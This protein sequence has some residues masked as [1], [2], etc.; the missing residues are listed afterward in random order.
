MG[1]VSS[2]SRADELTLT[3]AF[4]EGAWE[5]LPIVAGIIPFGLVAGAAAVDAG[6]G[7]E[8]AMSLSLLVFAGASQLAA[9]DLLARDAPLLV[10]LLT[11]GIINLRMA[12]YSASLAPPLA[13][14]P[15]LQR[16]LGAYFLVD[17]AYALTIMRVEQHPSRPHR[18]A[19]YLGVGVP[20]WV[21]W[22]LMT[23]VGA[24]LGSTI[25]AWLP[26]EATIPLVFLALLVPA[27]T[28]RATLAAAVVS[29]A[30]ATLAIGLPNNAGLLLGAFSGIGAGALVALR[31]ESRIVEVE[32]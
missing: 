15:L 21:N 14:V 8:G 5:V 12:M 30:V 9:I 24:V 18:M 4:R 27:V 25:P 23:A 1:A 22:Q 28:D 20:L 13:R 17:Q 11:V 2:S 16:L 6:L 32:R 19:Y 29:G 7:I 31:T 10:V 3:G 26:L